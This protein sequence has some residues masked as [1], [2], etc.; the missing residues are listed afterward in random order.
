MTYI[1]NN[2]EAQELSGRDK[3]LIGVASTTNYYGDMFCLVKVKYTQGI[4]K[5]GGTDSSGMIL[6]EILIFHLS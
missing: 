6:W 2:E 1:L 3:L 4:R 5:S